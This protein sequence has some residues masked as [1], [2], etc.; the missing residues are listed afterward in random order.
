MDV[1]DDDGVW[2]RMIEKR[3]LRLSDD[4]DMEDDIDEWSEVE[5]SE[6]EYVR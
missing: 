1:D 5:W 6:V 3:M 4:D 2:K